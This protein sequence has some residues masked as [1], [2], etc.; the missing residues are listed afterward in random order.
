MSDIKKLVSQI[1]NAANELLGQV[2]ELDN[3]IGALT[4]QRAKLM[5]SAVSKQDYFDYVKA[6]LKRK[7]EGFKGQIQRQIKAGPHGY[8]QLEDIASQQLGHAIDLLRGEIRGP[9]IVTDFAL[10]F[11]FGDMMAQ[12]L[13]DELDVLDWPKDAVPVKERAQLIAALDSDIAGLKQKRDALMGQLS[14]AGISG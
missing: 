10:Y 2:A 12:R 3:Q 8:G 9:V 4:D 14:E 6:M 5:D 7:G 1:K 11:Y 13:A